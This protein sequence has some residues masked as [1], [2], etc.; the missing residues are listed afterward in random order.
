MFLKVKRLQAFENLI[1]ETDL[2]QI[3]GEA[4]NLLNKANQSD[5]TGGDEANSK[6]SA[7]NDD[8]DR[9]LDMLFNLGED[10]L[11]EKMG[12]PAF[13]KI[14]ADP[15]MKTLFDN[16]FNYLNERIAAYRKE[17]AEALEKPE[18]N[19]AEIDKITDRLT[20]L[21]CRV[22]VVEI[23]YEKLASDNVADFSEEINKK[24]KDINQSLFETFSLR[25]SKPAEKTQRAYA[26]F[27]GAQSEDDKAQAA[28]EVFS[29]LQSAEIL[30]REIPE[31]EAGIKD[32]AQ[33]YTQRMSSE[34]GSARLEDIKAG[35]YVNKN[36]ASMI[37][38]I[39]EFQYTNWTTEQDIL[40]EANKLR[41]SING[42]PD[43]SQEAKEYL[44]RLVDQIQVQLI[45]R[46]K[47]KAFDTPKFKGIHY[48]F[49]KKLPLYERTAL[50]VNGKQIADD[51]KIMKFRKAAI[52]L[53]SI[54][55]SQT[56]LTKAGEAFQKTGKWLHD[57]YAKTLNTS[58]KFIGKAIKGRE[59]E[60][61]ADAFTRLFIPDTSVV[62]Q[63]KSKQVAED[64]VAPGVAAQTPGSISGMGPIV[65]PT[66]TSLGSGDNFGM[67]SR[68]KKKKG[69]V[70]NFANFLK[71][72]NN[73]R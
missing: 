9:L 40:T 20:K 59:G 39:F 73:N 13:R 63:P 70:L 8:I 45:E 52:A 5:K 41:T 1:L 30:A 53:L 49:N 58:A 12:D 42:F 16:Y 11:T 6:G 3:G 32:A 18:I 37:R 14:F 43:V 25:I 72:K 34:L 67:P 60:M 69:S 65:P 15:R 4:E 56:E 7:T 38:R 71:E 68:S 50:P 28:A 31:A 48:D 44:T 61:K 51:S 36:V 24:V 10:D 27:Q 17:L 2:I 35:V 57:I 29:T 55:N 22:R 33:T 66:E 62:D 23:I 19:E 21:V 54:F 46:A 26:K 64:A 47:N